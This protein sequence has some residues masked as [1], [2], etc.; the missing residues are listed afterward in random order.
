VYDVSEVVVFSFFDGKQWRIQPCF[1][2]S[3]GGQDRDVFKQ[4]LAAFKLFKYIGSHVGS[5]ILFAKNYE[6]HI[7]WTDLLWPDIE[8]ALKARGSWRIP[9]R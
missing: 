1:F 9:E 4:D 2:L 7:L 6:N 3:R 8:D 5:G